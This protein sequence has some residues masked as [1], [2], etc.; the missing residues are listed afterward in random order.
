MSDSATKGTKKD[1]TNVPARTVAKDAAEWA[2][3]A[4]EVATKAAKKVAGRTAAALRCGHVE[5]V[6]RALSMEGPP[7]AFRALA[8][9]TIGKTLGETKTMVLRFAS[10]ATD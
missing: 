8:E 4:A 9:L 10:A 2:A 7:T 5:M 6:A 1:A 3:L